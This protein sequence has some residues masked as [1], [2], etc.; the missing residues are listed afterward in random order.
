MVC[1][2]VME[3]SPTCGRPRLRS[4]LLILAWSQARPCRALRDVAMIFDDHASNG[5]LAV[6]RSLAT[7]ITTA[8]R[9]HLVVPKEV[10]LRAKHA[11]AEHHDL[12]LHFYDYGRCAELTSELQP[13]AAH[14]HTATQSVQWPL[15]Q[16]CTSSLDPTYT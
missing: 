12:H 11:L 14:I 15:Q 6:L 10:A 8:T 16:Y 9:A 13:L 5:G 2:T 3:R 7:A 1:R 4:V